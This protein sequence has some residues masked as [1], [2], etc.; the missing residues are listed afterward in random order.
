MGSLFLFD[1]NIISTTQECFSNI[2]NKVQYNKWHDI[3]SNLPL[4]NRHKLFTEI[5]KLQHMS[6]DAL[7]TIANKYIVHKLEYQ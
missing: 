2:D 6:I 5:N 7:E 3:F 1:R 4:K